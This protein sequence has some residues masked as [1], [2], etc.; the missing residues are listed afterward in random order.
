M[1]NLFKAVC[2]LLLISALTASAAAQ[3][4][5]RK[6]PA[7]E[8]PPEASASAES[9]NQDEALPSERQRALLLLDQLF[10]QA[11]GCDDETFRVRAQAEIADLLWQHNE[12]RARLQFEAA[13][14]AIA[15]IKPEAQEDDSALPPEFS[16]QSLL[17]S[18]VLRLIARHD[19]EWAGKLGKS[20][21]IPLEEISDPAEFSR[22]SRED[23]RQPE[24]ISQ[25]TAPGSAGSNPQAATQTAQG[26]TNLSLKSALFLKSARPA[27]L[28]DLLSQAEAA[29]NLREK[30]NLYTRAVL[31]ALSEN[32]FAQALAITEKIGQAQLRASFDSMARSRAAMAALSRDD[33]DAALRYARELPNP[34]QRAAL[35]NQMVQRLQN[36]KDIPRVA[37]IL[38]EAERSLAK[39]EDGADKARALLA[40]AGAAARSDPLR[41]FEIMQSAVSAINRAASNGSQRAA[42]Q[43]G[44]DPEALNFEQSFPLLARADFDRAVR[45]AQ[46]IEKREW[47]V[48]AQLTLCRG[49]LSARREPP[50]ENKSP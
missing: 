37:E 12:A 42:G 26:A 27:S 50:S 35:L 2:F 1:F 44:F 7:R 3:N 15:A 10:E 20:A 23:D 29:R 47:S 40:L 9:S 45:L 25:P 48:Q 4:L 41:G 39:A 38:N 13:F 36:K 34:S 24:T 28:P 21:G 8:K 18:E 32:D 11:R 19:P 31:Q 30:D 17:R 46:A 16:A 49:A 14:Q 6:P 33:F 5:P 43:T 22:P